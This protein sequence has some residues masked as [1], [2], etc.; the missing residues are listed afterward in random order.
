MLYHKLVTKAV[1]STGDGLA[2]IQDALGALC[3][4]PGVRIRQDFLLPGRYRTFLLLL[5]ALHGFKLM[6]SGLMALQSILPTMTRL[7]I[8]VC[9]FS[10]IGHLMVSQIMLA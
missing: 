6:I 2:G 8:P 10:L 5:M 9:S 3:L 1:R 7:Y 4:Y